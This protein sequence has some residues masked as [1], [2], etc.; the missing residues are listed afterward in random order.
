MNIAPVSHRQADQEEGD[1]L[2]KILAGVSSDPNEKP[3]SAA[4]AAGLKFEEPAVPGDPAKPAVPS[5]VEPA[6]ITIETPAD[7]PAPVVAPAMPASPLNEGLE[8]IKKTALE[9]LRPLVDK[10]NL[11]P[12]EKFDTLL[13]IIRS[14]DDQSL[15]ASAHDAAKAITDDTKRAEALLDVIK[16]I[17]YFGAQAGQA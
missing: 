2:Q 11:T 3:K 8:A 4:E 7:T 5:P 15:I 9:E 6:K 16:E 17:D 10:L 13:L 1:E 12:E 14:T